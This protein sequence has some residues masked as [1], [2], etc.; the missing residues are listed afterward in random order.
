MSLRL[1]FSFRSPAIFTTP[2]MALTLTV[3]VGRAD[4]C[5][6]RKA[7]YDH[8]H[9]ASVVV[10]CDTHLS[11]VVLLLCLV[12]LRKNDNDIETRG[13][14]NNHYLPTDGR[15]STQNLADV[16]SAVRGHG[17]DNCKQR[18]TTSQSV[19]GGTLPTSGFH[20]DVR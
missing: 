5:R 11:T 14:H 1:N 15:L 7:Y 18:C 20:P 8:D 6:R 4:L 10:A 9:A 12:Q 19:G 3:N 2:S 16:Q 13:F 17:T